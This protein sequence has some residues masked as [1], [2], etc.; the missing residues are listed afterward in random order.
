VSEGANRGLVP[1]SLIKHKLSLSCK[2]H[3]KV[4]FLVDLEPLLAYNTWMSEVPR[5]VQYF[6][7]SGALSN[8]SLLPPQYKRLTVS[9][10]G[11]SGNTLFA[12]ALALERN[13]YFTSAGSLLR[14]RLEAWE[15]IDYIPRGDEVDL[16]L[17]RDSARLITQATLSPIVLE[18][19]LGGIIKRHH[20]QLAESLGIK[21]VG[22]RIA[23]L[24]WANNEKRAEI[25]LSKPGN[26]NKSIEE[27]IEHLIARDNADLH[28]WI[29]VHPWLADYN[30][31]LE[32]NATDN[33]GKR[34]YDIIIDST[35][36][37]LEEDIK[38]ANQEFQ[39]LSA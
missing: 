5:P 19:K 21:L 27:L 13:A 12:K 6:V 30:D 17:D 37:T 25:A 3:K 24:K 31:I 15:E 35:L 39:R 4:R 33:E 7:E 28:Q 9:G 2:A 8:E 14:E 36:T 26:Q 11:N 16:E 32:P 18:A 10:K 29:R 38:H 1:L 20:E 34:I 23:I 22:P